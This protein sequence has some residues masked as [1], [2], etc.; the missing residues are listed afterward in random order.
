MSLTSAWYKLWGLD[1]KDVKNYRDKYKT[2]GTGAVVEKEEKPKKKEDEKIEDKGASDGTSPSGNKSV[3]GI[4]D[5]TTDTSPPVQ[6]LANKT[7]SDDPITV[8]TTYGEDIAA[9][10]QKEIMQKMLDLAGQKNTMGIGEKP[11]VIL[12][13]VADALSVLNTLKTKT[14]A[15]PEPDQQTKKLYDLFG[16]EQPTNDAKSPFD[17]IQQAWQDWQKNL[18]PVE[19]GVEVTPEQLQGMDSRPLAALGDVLN[20]DLADETEDAD[21]SDSTNAQTLDDQI[22]QDEEDAFTNV[23][24]RDVD[25]MNLILSDLQQDADTKVNTYLNVSWDYLIG[26]A[27]SGKKLSKAEKAEA[28]AAIDILKSKYGNAFTANDREALAM[29]LENKSSSGG[30]VMA[31]VLDSLPFGEA[32]M[33]RYIESVGQYDDYMNSQYDD[34]ALIAALQ[35][36]NSLDLAQQANPYAYLGGLGAGAAA[37]WYDIGEG[38]SGIDDL[39]N[40]DVGKVVENSIEGAGEVMTGMKYK[41]SSGAVFKANPNKTTTVLG[42]FDKDMKNIVNE[43]GNVK[44][45]DFGAKKGGF[46]VLNVPDEMY[47]NADQFWDEVNAKWLDEAIARGDDFILATKPEGKVMQSFNKLTGEWGSSG[48]AREYQHL[49]DNGY[50][51]DYITNTM[52]K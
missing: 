18:G 15:A 4:T 38:V 35:Q 3:S 17:R 41:P 20:P 2:T 7:V 30:A 28:K 43:M 31:G 25:A 27:T 47:K 1:E 46:N 33:N 12:P 40:K 52:V 6:T 22:N 26:L 45:T 42:S 32:V 44:S 16:L 11:S 51:Y 23:D 19:I 13:T 21:E 24:I 9:Q 50:H 37:Q 34:A 48:F 10:R 5:N 36:T 29:L 49:R 39:L 8:L 14:T